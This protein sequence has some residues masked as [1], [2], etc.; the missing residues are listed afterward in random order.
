[1][2]YR[3][4]LSFLGVEIVSLMGISGKKN[5]SIKIFDF[6]FYT[7]YNGNCFFCSKSSVDEV[8]LHIDYDKNL[9]HEHHS[10][11]EILEVNV[12]FIIA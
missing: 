8:I 1:M 3:K 4:L 5:N 10:F 2:R 11:P 6:L 12:F 9:A 7:R